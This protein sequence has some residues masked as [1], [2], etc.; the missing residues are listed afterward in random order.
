MPLQ[1]LDLYE[2]LETIPERLEAERL[3]H[4]EDIAGASAVAVVHAMQLQQV[5]GGLVL[6]K[7]YRR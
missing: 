4:A 7:C 1:T 2:I 3:S 6:F 5:L